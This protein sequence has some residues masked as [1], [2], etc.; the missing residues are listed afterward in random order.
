MSPATLCTGESVTWLIDGGHIQVPPIFIPSHSHL[1][2]IFFQLLSVA[3]CDLGSSWLWYWWLS[4]PISVMWSAACFTR[5]RLLWFDL[6]VILVI[7]QTIIDLC[8]GEHVAQFKSTVI[9]MPNGPLKITG[10]PFEADLYQ[11]ELK[12]EDEEVKVSTV[13]FLYWRMRT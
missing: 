8:A 7:I 4:N 9:L 11:T 13:N 1:W 3:Q 10:L 12:V 2:S 5:E 6:T